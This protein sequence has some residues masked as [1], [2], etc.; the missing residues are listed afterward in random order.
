MQPTTSDDT[1]NQL[2]PLY[3]QPSVQIMTEEW[4][5]IEQTHQRVCSSISLH[6]YMD[7]R[8]EFCK[9]LVTLSYF[10]GQISYSFFK[11]FNNMFNTFN[12]ELFMAME[13][14]R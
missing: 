4:K 14:F 2:V 6:D 9:E 12:F 1:S 10:G 5:L 7:A 13:E 11:E 8:P 3:K